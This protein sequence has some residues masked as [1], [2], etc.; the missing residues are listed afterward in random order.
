MT[1]KMFDLAYGNR[2]GGFDCGSLLNF[3]H[4]E[5]RST[6]AARMISG[7]MDSFFGGQRSCDGSC[8]RKESPIHFF[9]CVFYKTIKN[10]G[11]LLTDPRLYKTFCPLSYSGARCNCVYPIIVK[12]STHPTS[13]LHDEPSKV[14]P[15]FITLK[16]LMRA[17][18]QVAIE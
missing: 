3:V 4:G 12:R 13:R 2:G 1:L 14:R 10:S 9:D 15:P 18:A 5:Q 11:F 7:G 8:S 17:V 16:V 6:W